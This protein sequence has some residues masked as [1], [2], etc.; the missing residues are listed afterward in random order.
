[1]EDCKFLPNPKYKPKF[2]R[3]ALVMVHGLMIASIARFPL[4]LLGTRRFDSLLL[5]ISVSRLR[6]WHLALFYLVGSKLGIDVINK[7][8]S[9]DQS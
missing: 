3:G 1:M 6:N 2:R 8:R 9:G 7:E 5:A 4:R